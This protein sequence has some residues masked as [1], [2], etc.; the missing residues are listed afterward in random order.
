MGADGLGMRKKW[1]DRYGLWPMGGNKI[2]AYIC[3]FAVDANRCRTHVHHQAGYFCIRIRAYPTFRFA[4]L[5]K[6]FFCRGSGSDSETN[7]L[8]SVR[9][10]C[11]RQNRKEEKKKKKKNNYQGYHGFRKGSF[12]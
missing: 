10:P 1:F 5:G 4:P 3:A 7:C 9:G 11:A 2:G 12:F 8:K 6:V